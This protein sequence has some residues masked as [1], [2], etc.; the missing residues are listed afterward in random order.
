MFSKSFNTS[1][2]KRRRKNLREFISISLVT[3]YKRKETGMMN[4]SMK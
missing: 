4:I 2:R 3:I 1:S